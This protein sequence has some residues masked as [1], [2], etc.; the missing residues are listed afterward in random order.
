MRKE[1]L[2][3]SY[4]EGRH[5]LRIACRMFKKFLVLTLPPQAGEW[6]NG[7]SFGL[8]DLEALMNVA[9]KGKER[10]TAHTLKR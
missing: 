6:R 8:R 1:T 5:L 10:I 2:F 9:F 7:A 4:P 3:L